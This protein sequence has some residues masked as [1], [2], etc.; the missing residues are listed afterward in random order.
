MSLLTYHNGLHEQA[1]RAFVTGAYYPAL[2]AACALGERIL[3]HLVLDMRD[4][5]KS[6]DHYKKVYRKDS[7]DDWPFAV[8]VL[9][10][11]KVLVDSVGA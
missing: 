9:T 5:F 11:W 6:S 10:D 7:L 3:N 8:V 1:R 2:V 4:S